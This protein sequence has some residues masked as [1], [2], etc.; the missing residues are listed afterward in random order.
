M[1][2]NQLS[3]DKTD[4]DLERYGKLGDYS[5]QNGDAV[6][7]NGDKKNTKEGKPR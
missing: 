7:N 3:P 6:L 5:P 4:I 2:N 1:D